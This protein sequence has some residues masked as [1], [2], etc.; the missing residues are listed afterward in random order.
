MDLVTMQIAVFMFKYYDNMLP[1]A[2]D[3]DYFTFISFKH[4]YN[5]RLA[6]KSTYY[7]YQVRTNYGKFNLHFSGP[8]IWNN[9]DEETK[10]LSLHLFE[11]T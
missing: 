6:S 8:S 1:K 5:I 4:N 9:L 10:S 3:N 11:K 2:F 7:I